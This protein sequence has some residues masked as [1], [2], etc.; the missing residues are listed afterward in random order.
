M[1]KF[2]PYILFVA[3]ELTL[4]FPHS[5]DDSFSLSVFS[6]CNPFPFH[7]WDRTKVHSSSFSLSPSYYNNVVC[8]SHRHESFVNL[9]DKITLY[10]H[11]HWS[12]CFLVYPLVFS[13]IFSNNTQA[14]LWLSAV[15]ILI[16]CMRPKIWRKRVFVYFFS[17]SLFTGNDTM[18][19]RNLCYGKAIEMHSCALA[20]LRDN[21][22]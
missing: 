18:Q 12:R 15:L 5:N 11:Y 9:L 14:W 8:E 17:F 2:L 22:I 20:L 19:M 16:C 7:S 6:S 1:P 3:L 21:S 13:T 10:I 4:L